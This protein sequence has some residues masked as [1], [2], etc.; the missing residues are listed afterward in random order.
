MCSRCA[1]ESQLKITYGI[2]RHYYSEDVMTFA[3]NLYFASIWL[4]NVVAIPALFVL[5]AWSLLWNQ[6]T[7]RLVVGLSISMACLI[8]IV[9]LRLHGSRVLMRAGA[10]PAFC[11]G[12][13][14]PT[15]VSE[16]KIAAFEVYRK[17][18][19]PPEVVGSAWG[20]FLYRRGP[21]GPRIFL[22]KFRGKV[23]GTNRWKSG[24]TLVQLNNDLLK[25]NK[26]LR[27]HPTMDYISLGSWFACSNHGN[28]GATAG[29]S[30]DAL[31]DARVLDMTTDRIETWTY[32]QIRER[33]DAEHLRI[34]THKDAAPCRYCI[35]DCEFDNTAENK[36]V[37]KRCI[38]ID[39]AAAA[40]E[41]LNPTQDLRLLFLG[42]ARSVG[43]GVQWGPVYDSEYHGHRDPHFCSRFCQFLQVDVCSAVGGWY[44]SAYYEER[45][46]KYLKNFTG[47]TSLYHA[48]RWMPTVWPIQT[49]SVV[50]GGYRN[51]EIFFKLD[52]VLTGE[53]LF[54]LVHNLIQ[55]HKK[56][57]GRSEIR[58]G[59]PNSAICL[60]VSMNKEFDA[61]F[62]LLFKEHN[63][64]RVALHPGK[65][66][67]E[68]PTKP[69]TRVEIGNL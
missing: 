32:S 10:W 46:V 37:Q 12:D 4:T 59:A 1:A 14:F 38:V 51:F 35:V 66:N 16:L 13:Y 58:H 25:N 11:T 9:Y 61:P 20:F 52:E 65:W 42:A 27:T 48:N 31:K 36:D 43:L 44:E 19:R 67:H 50:L 23:E 8:W 33:F 40:A 57:G 18:G 22:H 29:K 34:R 68:L 62:L 2:H 26:T 30:S 24:T 45:G 54:R 28:G 39:S 63:V 5:L 53:A 64:Q 60:D 6:V 47:V 56:H 17:S 41:W 21:R 69:C 15:S 55:M 7:S 49:I 3:Y